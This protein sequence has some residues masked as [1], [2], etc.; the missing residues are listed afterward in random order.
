M[1][2][3]DLAVYSEYAYS[4]F[5]EV[6]Q[7]Q[8]NLFNQASGG[9]IQ[10]Q[11]AAHQGDFSD[12]AFFAKIAGGTVRRRNAYGSGTVSEK[13]LA[14]LVDTMVKVASGT[15]PI[16]IDPGQF[17]WIQQNPEVAGVALGQQLAVDTL[18]DMLNTGLGAT[19]AAIGTQASNVHDITA[20]TAPADLM[21]FIAQADAAAKYGD[22]SN[23]IQAWVMHSKPMHNLYANALTNA[24]RL[25]VY[26]TVNVLR[27]PFG[28]LLIMTD[29]PNLVTTGTPNV[30]NTLGLVPGALMLDQNNDFTANEETKNGNENIVRTYQAEWSYEL[31]IM[32]FSW[33]KANGGKS[34]N[35]A[36]L[37]TGTNW[38]KYA[39]SNKDLAGV[40]LK[41]H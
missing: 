34:P 18:A 31:G 39:T 14:H 33:D 10:L 37:L 17:K 8:V 28:R 27:D 19:V 23:R 26:G 12:V 15:P 25:F 16:R 4:S 5:S 20:A 29:S 22:M 2:L 40:L 38:D 35:D 3:S 11:A 30:Y 9:T 41:S 24:E 1:A 21:S 32:G 7:Q 6:L 13:T 36:A